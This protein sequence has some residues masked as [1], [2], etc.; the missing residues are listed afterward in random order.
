MLEGKETEAKEI[1][2]KVVAY[3]SHQHEL[4][5]MEKYDEMSPQLRALHGVQQHPLVFEEQITQT[6]A[7]TASQMAQE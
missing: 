5:H 7:G 6:Q 1:F 4:Y 3:C 2:D